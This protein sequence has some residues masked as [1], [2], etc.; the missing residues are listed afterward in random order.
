M[1]E[2]GTPLHAF[3]TAGIKGGIHVR[4]AEANEKLST[5]DGIERTLKGSE[6]VIADDE[7]VLC[8]AGILGG[9]KAAVSLET[10]EIFLESAIFDAISIRKTAKLHG[11]NTD[12][13]FRFERGV[14]PDLTAYALNR[15]VDLIIEVAGGKVVQG[16][17]DEIIRLPKAKEIQI[18]IKQISALI[19][20][21]LNDDDTHRLLLDL[22]FK[23]QS[24]KGSLWE[25]IAPN[26]RTDVNRSADVAEEILR[27]IG[28]NAIPI[29]EKWQ[30]SFQ[31]QKGISK[32][33]FGNQI[34]EFLVAQ[35]YSEIMMNSLSKASYSSLI[36]SDLGVSL[37][38]PLSSELSQMRQTLV[39]GLL[40]TL[41]YN[42]NRQQNDLKLFEFGAIYHKKATEYVET[43]QIAFAISGKQ[44]V[45]N[46][47]N[48]GSEA[49][50]FTLKGTFYSL[51]NRFGINQTTEA[52][53]VD[54]PFFAEGLIISLDK[55]NIAE[56]GQIDHSLLR[57]RSVVFKELPKTF[58]VRRDF[59]LLIDEATSY[60]DIERIAYD[61][62]KHLLKS[63]RLFDVY[64]GE[65]IEAGKK[66]Y[67][68]S[69]HF[70]DTERTLTDQVIDACM[71]KIRKNLEKTAGASLR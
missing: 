40:E 3:D 28:F 32:H 62:E 1:H 17:S 50:F 49:T 48:S 39:F 42:Q 64:E 31:P 9:Q 65:K 7:N 69:F 4:K 5:L 55:Q 51:L 19:G 71:E 67:A 16:L 24:K 12:A 36:P 27:I 56:I 13:S 11:L 38:N 37:L 25:I 68:V 63:V 14:D 41:V 6:L 2:L 59:S 23:I 61:S 8:L 44:E 43:N 15:A 45:E 18:D 47:N 54:S 22:D 33:T 34:S 58:E 21:D 29:P 57:E 35:G 52:Q 60:K 10:Q 46:W 53:L 66:S 26:Y 30:Y 20:L 70:Q